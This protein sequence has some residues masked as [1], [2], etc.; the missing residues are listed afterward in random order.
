M[1]RAWCLKKRVWVDN[2]KLTRWCMAC[3]CKWL[4]FLIW[5]LH[6]KIRKEVKNVKKNINRTG[7]LDND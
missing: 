5:R 2:S 6:R 4:Q 7:S 1:I 3:E